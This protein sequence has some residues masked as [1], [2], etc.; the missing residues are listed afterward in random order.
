MAIESS[1]RISNFYNGILNDATS[2]GTPYPYSV[3]KDAVMDLLANRE[4]TVTRT[5][6]SQQLITT[7]LTDAGTPTH[8]PLPP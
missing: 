7:A 5:G 8:P 1:S 6:A 2:A 3:V 4:T